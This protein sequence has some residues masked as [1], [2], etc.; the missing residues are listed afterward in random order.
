MDAADLKLRLLDAD[1]SF[2]ELTEILH[3]AYAPLAE[4]QLHFY[5]T[6]QGPDVTQKRALQGEC[7]VGEV[8]GRLACTITLVPPERTEGCGWYERADVAKFTQFGVHPEFKGQGVGSNL[9]DLVERRAR[10]MG[11]T[12]LALDTAETA[13]DLIATYERRGYRPVD[14]VDR[15]PTVNYRSVVLSK[16]L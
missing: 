8:N 1:D 10:E 4:R 13:D 9:L 12:E 6:H 15:R 14:R 7:W 11:A 2:E 3:L 5:A 16:R